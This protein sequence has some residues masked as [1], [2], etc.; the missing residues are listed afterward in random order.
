MISKSKLKD[1]RSLHL[2]KFRQMYDKFIAEGEK[3]TT[4]LLNNR[5]YYIDDIFITASAVKK[6]QKTI[7]NNN[8][9]IVSDKEMTSISALK[10][11]SDIL[12]VL[13]RSEDSL[14]YLSKVD[15]CAIYLDGVQDPGNVGT[16]IRVAD[17]FGI[18]GVI[19]SEDTA[20]FF[21]PK[22]VQ[23][24]MGSMVNVQLS[25]TY[26]SKIKS[27]NKPV[28][29][30]YMNGQNISNTSI[31]NNAIIVMGSEGK[32]ISKENEAYI[33]QT[34]TIFGQ[35]S[36]VAESLNVSV[37]AGIICAFWKK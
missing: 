19:R 26:L 22:V 21:H 34:I 32:G 8:C 9:N 2:P 4:E 12:L 13:Q 25:S 20:D 28:F 23:S 24:S 16:I 18:D 36:K 11:P 35:S 1:I 3:V 14:D 27:F 15:T 30:T 6:Y 37:A 17:W 10:T 29:G 7:D 33:D 5:K 31:A